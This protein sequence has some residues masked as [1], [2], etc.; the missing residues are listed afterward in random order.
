LLLL[1]LLPVRFAVL[2]CCFLFIFISFLR[3][4]IYVGGSGDGGDDDQI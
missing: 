3:F 2:V 4:D 1:L